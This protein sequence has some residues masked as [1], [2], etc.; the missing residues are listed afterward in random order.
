MGCVNCHHCHRRL[1]VPRSRGPADEPADVEVP[2]ARR[3]AGVVG[4]AALLVASAAA[5]G[6]E[7]PAS[8]TLYVTAPGSTGIWAVDVATG[9]RVLHE[10]GRWPVVIALH[11]ATALA[12]GSL[13]LES[14][15]AV[16]RRNVVRYEPA[17]GLLTG[18]S[19]Q[20]DPGS[21]ETRGAGPSLDPGATG[22]LATRGGTLLYLRRGAGPIRI[23]PW[24]GDRSVISQSAEP[25]VGPG[26]P[27]T[28]PLDLV[29][30]S[31]A[32]LLVADAFEGLVRVRLADGSRE[33]AHP[34]TSFIEGPYLFDVLPDGRLVHAHGLDSSNAL[35]A[36][37]P[38]TGRDSLLSG[39]GRG[40]G[41][42]FASIHDLVVAP[43][44][45]VYVFDTVPPTILAVDPATGNRAV[46]SGGREGRG[47]GFELPGFLDRPL[48]ATFS[49]LARPAEPRPIRRRIQASP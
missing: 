4:L 47:T 46:V 6:A 18:V 20:V 19:G 7:A 30:E 10:V 24:T 32:T 49:P 9:A 13:L 36:F 28:R 34:G 3:R 8:L 14:T 42:L 11:H 35:Y 45:L 26:F 43:D 2:R 48:L 44:G 21:D 1:P 39:L 23:D 22:L 25:A 33:L 27:M 12:D 31:D 37:D 16:Q 15:N 17:R 41:E 40:D 38:A 5:T 29:L